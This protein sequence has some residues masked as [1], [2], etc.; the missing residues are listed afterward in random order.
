SLAAGIHDAARK[1]DLEKVRAL[2]EVNPELL[3]AQDKDGFSPLHL[4]AWKGHKEVVE[5]L[6]GRKAEV[7]LKSKDGG[8]PL[9]WAAEGGSAEV[10]KMLLA[11]KAEINAKDDDG[12]T[13]LHVAV[14]W[15]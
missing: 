14:K 7:N 5:L 15:G 3:R 6:L 9:H 2:L 13:P 8:A 12:D 1:G 11:H 4:A 10:V